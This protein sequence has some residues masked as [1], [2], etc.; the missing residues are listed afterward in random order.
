M[1]FVGA[2]LALAFIWAVIH[3]IRY[4]L[5]PSSANSLLPSVSNNF[6]RNSAWD[7]QVFLDSFHLRLQTTAW[8][9]YHDLLATEFKKERSFLL[10]QALIGFYDLGSI[11]GIL[12]MLTGLVLLSWTCGLCTLSLA[13]KITNYTN[14]VPS[15]VTTGLVRRGLEGATVPLPQYESFIKPIASYLIFVRSRR[16]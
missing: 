7:T 6:R 5:T 12:G 2:V 11:F 3:S 9:I 4:I 16:F 13:T 8:N 14:N 10:S 15:S 1:S